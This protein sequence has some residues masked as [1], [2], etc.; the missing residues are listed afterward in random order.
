MLKL[1][2][3][4]LTPWAEAVTTT[5]SSESLPVLA[6][7]VVAAVVCGSAAWALPAQQRIPATAT[8]SALTPSPRTVMPRAM[9]LGSGSASA[10]QL[11]GPRRTYVA[12]ELGCLLRFR[13]MIRSPGMDY[14][15]R[16]CVTDYSNL[17][18]PWHQ[19]DARCRKARYRLALGSSQHRIRSWLYG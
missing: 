9:A 17:P 12:P 4:F 7:P 18:V 5:S 1:A 8:A 14:L 6:A 13:L 11:V 16:Q 10:G 3:S 15:K 19:L 2:S